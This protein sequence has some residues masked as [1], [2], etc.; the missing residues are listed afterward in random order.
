M[1]S[2]SNTHAIVNIWLPTIRFMFPIYRD[3][4][5]QKRRL[6]ETSDFVFNVFK[7][8]TF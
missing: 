3:N 5:Q 6:Y 4:K 1:I 8:E 2:I 7:L